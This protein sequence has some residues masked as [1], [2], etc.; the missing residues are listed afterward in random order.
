MSKVLPTFTDGARF[1]KIIMLQ[2]AWLAGIANTWLARL[3]CIL[4]LFRLVVAVWDG[5]KRV[6]LVFVVVL[7]PQNSCCSTSCACFV[8]PIS[9]G[10]DT[11]GAATSTAGLFQWDTAGQERFRTIT[12]AYYRGADGIIMVYDV[13]GQVNLGNSSSKANRG[14]SDIVVDDDAIGRSRVS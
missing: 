5:W 2:D 11:A 13:T 4:Q 3:G 12:S 6:S 14:Q 7:S 1:H 8:R 9:S 10:W